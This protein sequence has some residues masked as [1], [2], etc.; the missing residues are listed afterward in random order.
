MDD[1][2]YPRRRRGREGA[3]GKGNKGK[4]KESFATYHK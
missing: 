4:E 2:M 1:G 3:R